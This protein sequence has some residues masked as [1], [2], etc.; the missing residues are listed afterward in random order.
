MLITQ[1]RPFTLGDVEIQEILCYSLRAVL[2]AGGKG[3][4][5]IDTARS[6]SLFPK[7]LI[8]KLVISLQPPKTILL[9]FLKI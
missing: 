7:T 5:L 3:S 2:R 4:V 1:L 6:F 9:H 8:L